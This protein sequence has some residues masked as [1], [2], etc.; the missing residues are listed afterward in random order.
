MTNVCNTPPLPAPPVRPVDRQELIQTIEDLVQNED[1]PESEMWQLGQIKDH[2][3]VEQ[4]GDAWQNMADTLW[5]TADEIDSLQ[6]PRVKEAYEALCKLD[7][8]DLWYTVVMRELE[9]SSGLLQQ[10]KGKK[11]SRALATTM[12]GEYEKMKKENGKFKRTDRQS[13]AEDEVDVYGVGVRKA[14]ARAIREQGNA[15]YAKGAYQ[16]ASEHY[17][18]AMGYDS[19][20]AVYP[21]NRAACMVKLARFFEA[22]LDCSK[23][24]ALDASNHK[25]WFRRGVSKAGMGQLDLAVQDFKQ[26]LL[27]QMGD[28]A[29][30]AELHRLSTQFLVQAAQKVGDKTLTPAQM[31]SILPSRDDLLD[32]DES[33]EERESNG[34]EGSACDKSPSVSEVFSQVSF[35]IAF[36]QILKQQTGIDVKVPLSSWNAPLQCES[37]PKSV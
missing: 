18:K 30:Y 5:E 8:L 13:S 23:A 25:A 19:D 34:S 37:V 26:V 4:I 24:I 2:G 31:Q 17:T 14:L 7:G 33:S 29:A 15:A 27:L 6:L 21:L 9:A 28:K 35:A 20:E 32:R 10:S 36:S 12:S 16:E 11:T 3:W 1:G 22:D